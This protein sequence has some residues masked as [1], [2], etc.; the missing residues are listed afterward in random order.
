MWLRF[1]LV[2][3][4]G[5][6]AALPATA[7]ERV[8]SF[9]ADIEVARTG[10]VLVTE[11][12]TIVSEGKKFQHGIYRDI[13]L[14]HRTADDMT[15]V[16]FEVLKVERDGEPENNIRGFAAGGTRVYL[17]KSDFLLPPGEHVYRWTYRIDNQIREDVDRDMFVWNVTG[18]WDF[19]IEKASA[20]VK[21]PAGTKVL[22]TF[23]TAGIPEMSYDN[24]IVTVDG[25]KLVFSSVIP[26]QQGGFMQFR[27]YIPKNSI[28]RLH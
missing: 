2:V 14:F 19:V 28:E 3:L 18:R 27:I 1:A 22:G 7:K 23:Q 13:P 15:P 17:G 9:H 5:F 26:I 10:K 12:I 6:L 8:K 4:F 21:L 16:G 25:A 20:S 11:T 24:V